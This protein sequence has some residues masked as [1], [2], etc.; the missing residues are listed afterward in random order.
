[1]YKLCTYNI[2]TCLIKNDYRVK[3]FNKSVFPTITLSQPENLR[4]LLHTNHNYIL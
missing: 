3:I 4:E 1:M 2:G